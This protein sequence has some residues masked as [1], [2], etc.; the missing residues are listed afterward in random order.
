MGTIL[1]ETAR[2][3]IREADWSTHRASQNRKPEQGHIAQN[4][5]NFPPYKK[6]I[7]QNY[8]GPE[9]LLLITKHP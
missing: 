6:K 7:F 2:I 9:I 3:W 1:M 5:N 4:H 8:T